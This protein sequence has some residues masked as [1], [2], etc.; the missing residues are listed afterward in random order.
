[1]KNYYCRVN[2]CQNQPRVERIKHQMEKHIFLY[3]KMCRRSGGMG[4]GVEWPFPNL[5]FFS[6]IDPI[7]CS[8]IL[9][10]RNTSKRKHAVFKRRSIEDSEES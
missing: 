8:K 9:Q 6:L 10:N 4:V 7:S 2:F 3:L 5:R 1:M